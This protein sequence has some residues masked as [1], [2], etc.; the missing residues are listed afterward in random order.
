[1]HAQHEADPRDDP[2]VTEKAG[3]PGG[4]GDH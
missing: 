2:A 4:D 3:T 1:M